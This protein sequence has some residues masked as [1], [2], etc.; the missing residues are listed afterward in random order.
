[1]AAVAATHKLRLETGA[2]LNLFLR[3]VGRR[4]DGYHELESIFHS[5]DFADDLDVAPRP[6]AT[7]AVEMTSESGGA[8]AFPPAEENLAYVAARRLQEVTGSERGAE[9]HIRKRIPLGG[10]LGGGSS[11]AAGVLAAL[12]ELWE[13]G[14]Q[15][16]RLLEVAAEIGSDVPFCLDGGATCLVTGRGENLTPLPGPPLPMW[17]VLGLSDRPVSTARV[18]GGLA[19]VPRTGPAVAPVTMAIGAGDAAELAQLLHNDL[20]AVALQQRPELREHKEVL[21]AAGALGVGLSGSGPT[22]FGVA[23]DESSAREI[24]SKVGTSFDRVVVA[25]SAPNCVRFA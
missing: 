13:L 15:R 3:V 25:S 12:D 20:E 19:G 11:N 4:P 8:V 24:A 10:G 17:F 1:M 9:I 23:P 5:L 18:Y 22:L 7:I 21:V 2:K 6:G 16:S 14:L